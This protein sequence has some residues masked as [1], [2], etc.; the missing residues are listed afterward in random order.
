MCQA[1][2]G[3]V[4]E[5]D[6]E[7]NTFLALEARAAHP[8]AREVG[9]KSVHTNMTW[10]LFF[11]QQCM[12]MHAM[13]VHEHERKR[14]HEMTPQRFALVVQAWVYWL[15]VMVENMEPY[16]LVWVW[17]WAM[18]LRNCTH[19]H[20]TPRGISHAASHN[21]QMVTA[22]GAV[23]TLS[24]LR[25]PLFQP[26]RAKGRMESMGGCWRGALKGLQN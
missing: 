5:S 15:G 25:T 23:V 10:L 8:W 11:W 7:L 3:R 13:T 4:N 26:G 9:Q 2:R 19:I 24:Q 14:K 21:P 20:R 18:Q 16:A 22:T 12:H 1:D 17:V 6:L